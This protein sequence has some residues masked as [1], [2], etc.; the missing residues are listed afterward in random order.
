MSDTPLVD[1]DHYIDR[2]EAKRLIDSYQAMKNELI[3]PKFAADQEEYGVLPNSEAFNEKSILAILAQP[4]CVGVRIHYGLKND[5]KKGENVPL[6]VAVLVG[7]NADGYNMWGSSAVA[8]AVQAKS[9]SALTDGGD[10]VI[11]EDSQRCPPWPDPN[12]Q[13]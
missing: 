6:V 3:N 5:V 4:G 7:V 2:S 12:P 10:G 9:A 8:G 13:P 11:L 1:L